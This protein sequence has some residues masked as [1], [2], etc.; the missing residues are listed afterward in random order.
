MR[1]KLTM[2]FAAAAWFA[3]SAPGVR[4]VRG[5]DVSEPR[6][7]GE[8]A[9]KAERAAQLVKMAASR[10]GTSRSCARL[11]MVG[12]PSSCAGIRS[13]VTAINRAGSS[14]LRYG[15]G[16]CRGSPAVRWRL[17]RWRRR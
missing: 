3:A 15:P 11:A 6:A 12:N 1:F 13:F 4:S 17:P 7:G 10:P 14:T 5:D 9:A 8:D 16:V 2:L